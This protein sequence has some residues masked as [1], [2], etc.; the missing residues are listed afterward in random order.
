MQQYGFLLLKNN[1]EQSL[2][3]GPLKKASPKKEMKEHIYYFIFRKRNMISTINCTNH[4][5]R[6]LQNACTCDTCVCPFHSFCSLNKVS[7]NFSTVERKNSSR[8]TWRSGRAEPTNTEWIYLWWCSNYTESNLNY[9]CFYWRNME[10]H[11]SLYC[12][13]TQEKHFFYETLWLLLT[14]GAEHMELVGLGGRLE[15]M[16]CNLKSLNNSVEK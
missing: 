15:V 14:K 7:N 5:A 8:V 16:T 9:L 13:K 2:V 1:G 4:F 10:N 11:I 3:F 12:R 6:K